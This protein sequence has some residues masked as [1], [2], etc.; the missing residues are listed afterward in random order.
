V[1]VAVVDRGAGFVPGVGVAGFFGCDGGAGR[2]ALGSVGSC[3]QAGEDNASVAI[4]IKDFVMRCIESL[5]R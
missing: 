2:W 3:A 1:R 4:K 5:R